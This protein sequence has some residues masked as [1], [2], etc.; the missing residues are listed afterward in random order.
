MF[1]AF[2][3]ASL[4]SSAVNS[5]QEN[6]P[7]IR[8]EVPSLIPS[9][10]SLKIA[11]GEFLLR[12]GDAIVAKGALA[13][14]AKL[15][16]EEFRTAF[17]IKLQANGNSKA[18]IVLKIDKKLAEEQYR[19]VIGNKVDISGGSYQAVAYGI[20][21]LLQ[22]A[23]WYEGGFFDHPKR[24]LFA[25]PTGLQMA[26]VTINDKPAFGYR[27]AMVDVARK[28]HSIDTLKQVV[29]LCRFYKVR[30]LQLHLTDDQAF[31]FPSTAFPKVNSS[32]Q[33]GGPIY[34]LAEIKDLVKYADTR[35]VTIVPELD[36]PGHSATLIRTMPDL[37]KI[38]DTKPYEHH[39]T[40]NFANTEVMKALETMVGEMCEVFKSSPYFHIGGDEADIANVAQHPDFQKLIAEYGLT[41]N[42]EQEL[43]R[44]FLGQMNE[45]VKKRGKK[46]IV[47]EGFGRDPDSKFPIPKDIT[48]MEFESAYQTAPELIQDGYSMINT[49]WT[50]L[51]IVNRH[52]WK[53][54][55]VYDWSI[56]EFGRVSSL[57]QTVTW[58]NTE[59]A[60]GIAGAQACEWEQPEYLAVQGFLGVLPA[61]S[62]R[63]W[64]PGAKRDYSEFMNRLQECDR[65]LGY[66]LSPMSI[67]FEGLAQTGEN[68]FD[69]MVFDDEALAVLTRRPEGYS[70]RYTTD[71]T[72][73]KAD[74]PE[75]K[76]NLSIVQSMT[77]RA[78]AFDKNGKPF[79]GEF[80]RTLYKLETKT[81]NLATGKPVTCSGGTQGPQTPDLVVDG[82]LDLG[83]S[84][85]AAPA[86]QWVQ[87]D[88]QKSE[89]IK[90]I[91]VFPYWDGRR[92]YQYTVEVSTGGNHWKLVADRSTN[93][94]P[95]SSD[96]DTIKLTDCN[97]RYIRVNML[98]CSANEGVHIVEIQA[99]P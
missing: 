75:W 20:T 15:C 96:G 6:F 42:P 43:Y 31:T 88:L 3:L 17:G 74:S 89:S 54:K 18:T 68:E 33:H 62:E 52:V 98:K 34:T 8:S 69:N 1:G 56:N 41:K 22:W 66:L 92:Y 28:Y 36:L 12:N 48:V 67:R 93:T 5:P 13:P 35:G 91:V 53:P 39:A 32:N 26:R 27:G 81:T 25:S 78:Q 24:N 55:K 7:P 83:S 4:M 71:G 51:Y 65:L 30:Y 49:S 19:L 70:V 23:R 14:I 97:A 64:N 72:M 94:I 84:W 80:A 10:Q 44:R 61:M 59:N 82:N 90:R 77:I 50:P 76:D 40:V 37:F 46:M 9:P 21:S 38:K 57:W 47:W 73:P 87:V 45:I 11:K 85:W 2:L 60:Q 86:P 58:I 29:T 95:S 99:W 79:G 63:V 16:A